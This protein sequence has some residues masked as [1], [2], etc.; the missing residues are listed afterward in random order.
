M[1]NAAPLS[2]T[3][4]LRPLAR[5]GFA[6]RILAS[7]TEYIAVAGLRAG[8]RLPTERTLAAQLGVGRSTVREALQ[9]WQAMGLVEI[10]TG[11]GTYLVQ[12]VRRTSL[13]VPVTINLDR[14]A[15][16]NSLELRRAIETDAARLAARRATDAEVDAMGRALEEMEAVYAE[17]GF[18]IRQ[19]QAF[20]AALFR[21]SGNPLY[22]QIFLQI[23]PRISEAF[24]GSRENPFVTEPFA[25]AS[26]PDH[27]RLFEAVAARDPEAAEAA[28]TRILDFVETTLRQDARDDA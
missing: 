27:R 26:Q 20:H 17:H 8:D 11:S 9:T 10:R 3:P 28:V 7:L 21:A 15:V 16:L 25:D 13:H 6:P 23:I 2:P 12:E 4:S 19:D 22:P 14:A 18:A 1:E 24:N 5:E